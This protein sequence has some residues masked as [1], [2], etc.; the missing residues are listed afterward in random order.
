M[1]TPNTSEDA[2]KQDYSYIAGKNVKCI[3]MT[4]SLCCT[5]ETHTTL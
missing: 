4:G 2:E 5:A 3:C 1:T